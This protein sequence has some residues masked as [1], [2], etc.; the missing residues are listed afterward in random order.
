MKNYQP[1][2]PFLLVILFLLCTCT[3]VFGQK[4]YANLNSGY[5][6]GMSKQGITIVDGGYYINDFDGTTSATSTRFTSISKSFGEGINI[7]GA[8]GYKITKEISAELGLSYLKS[9]S[10]NRR[11]TDFIS[12]YNERYGA[13]MFQFKPAIKLS[14]GYKKVNPYLKFGPVIGI[15]KIKVESYNVIKNSDATQAPVTYETVF[16]STGGLAL[17]IH[18][19]IGVCYQLSSNLSLFGE[20]NSI[21]LSYSPDKG[22]Y[23]KYAINGTDQVHNLDYAYMNYDYVN[24]FTN[25]E[26]ATPDNSKPTKVL[27]IDYPFGSLGFNLGINCFF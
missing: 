10:L 6:I 19:G 14:A 12:S 16:E 22:K 9:N 17:G 25:T 15:G 3:T 23:T 21:N 1:T 2:N 20:L 24:A 8:L 18:S 11:Y 4:W 13:T 27:K 5:A 26:N 7:S